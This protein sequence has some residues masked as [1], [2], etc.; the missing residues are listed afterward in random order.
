MTMMT[1]NLPDTE[2]CSL[3]IEGPVARLTLMR[4]DVFN[5]M[6]I[7]MI[8]EIISLLDWTEKRSV[9]R[10]GNLS[11]DSGNSYIR[12]LVFSGKGRHFCAG[13]DINMMR[14]AGAKSPAENRIDSERLDRLFN[15]L[16]A[17]PCFTIGIVQGVALGGGAGLVACL[18]HV[19]VEPRTRIA[20]SEGKLGILPAVI[21]PYVYRRVGS[22]QFRRLAM[23]AGRID[24]EEALRIGMVDQAEESP[25][26]A[27]EAASGVIDEVLTTGPMAV[28]E[29]K[30][31]TL[32]F[33]R[34]ESTD[35]DLRLWTLDKT[36]EMRGS[37]EGQEGLSSFLE[38]RPANWK[39]ESE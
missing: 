13:A 2:L 10:M 37:N 19:I 15:T 39:P 28:A 26:A 17:H 5:A 35:E 6:N 32:I 31:L 18:D 12:V 20:L 1:D 34:W 3:E 33:D 16:W 24:A 29:A 7:Q 8:S 4:P 22:S 14:D 11:D 25:E 38:K 30:R 21:G 27:H 9:A 23:L 36:S